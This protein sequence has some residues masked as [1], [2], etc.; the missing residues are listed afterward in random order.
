MKHDLQSAAVYP[1]DDVRIEKIDVLVPP[2]EVVFELPIP[3]TIA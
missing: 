1:T 3:P 2:Q